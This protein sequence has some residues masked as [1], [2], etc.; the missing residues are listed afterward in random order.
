M[1][2]NLLRTKASTPQ[3]PAPSL[4]A[5]VR[6]LNRPVIVTAGLAV[7]LALGAW[8]QAEEPAVTLSRFEAPVSTGKL[9]YAYPAVE[10]AGSVWD[11]NFSVLT[12]RAMPTALTVKSGA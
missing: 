6:K 2:Y 10:V 3:L 7:Y 12:P 5:H 1:R 8:G 9:L 4:R 11:E